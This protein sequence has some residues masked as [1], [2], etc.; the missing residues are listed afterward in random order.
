MTEKISQSRPPNCKNLPGHPDSAT[1]T[2]SLCFLSTTTMTEWGNGKA[3]TQAR[4]LHA[5]GQHSHRRLAL[6]RGLARRQF[7]L[8]ESEAADPEA[9]SRQVRRLL[10]G[11][12]PRRAEHAGQCAQAQPHRYLLRAV[13][14]AFGTRG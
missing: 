12:S 4:R 7:Q 6:S 8:S 5:A 14:T 10:H 9:G 11:R 13:H 1:I 3:S 2:A